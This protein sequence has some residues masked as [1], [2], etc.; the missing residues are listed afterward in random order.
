MGTARR[1]YRTATLALVLG[2]ASVACGA[3]ALIAE[4]GLFLIGAVLFWL[5]AVVLGIWS[6]I[7]IGRAGGNLRGRALAG[8]GMAVPTVGGFVLGFGLL[9][10]T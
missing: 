5:L 2:M 9:P 1:T 3:L 8:W 7:A 6:W 4:S 10:V